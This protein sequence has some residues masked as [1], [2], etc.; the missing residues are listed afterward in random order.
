[1][2]QTNPIHYLRGQLLG[3]VLTENLS[4]RLY[5]NDASPYEKL[6][7][8][9]IRPKNAQDCI[10]LVKYA[11][12]HNI[13]VTARSAGTSLAGQAIGEGLIVDTGRYMNRI[14]QID[15]NKRMAKVE[16]GVVRSAL[17]NQLQSFGLQFGPDPSTSDYC[18]L[19]GMVGN[20]AWGLHSLR[21]GTTRDRIVAAKLLFSEGSLIELGPLS[22]EQLQ[23]KLIQQSS[24]GHLYRTVYDVL[25]LHASKIRS[26]F[27]RPDGLSR[28]S[29]YALDDMLNQQPWSPQGEPFNLARLLC[30]AEGTLGLVTELT[31]KLDPLPKETLLC[32]LSFASLGQALR[33]VPEL[34]TFK[35][36]ALELLDDKVL[37]STLKSPALEE[38]RFWLKGKPGAVLLTEF[39]ADYG[40]GYNLLSGNF[41]QFAQRFSSESVAI[42][43]G[44]K[45]QKVW[46]LRKAGLGSLMGYRGTV[47]PVTGVED[48][49]V[50]VTQLADYVVEVKRYLKTLDTDCVVYGPAGR[51][52]L[53][54]R[55]LMDLTTV[56]GQKRYVT[57]M[58]QVNQI[59]KAYG[60]TVTG[61]HGDGRMRAWYLQEFL[62]VEM[63]A[64]MQQVKTAFDSSGVFN[65]HIIVDA[66]KPDN[67][68]RPT[69][70]ISGKFETYFDWTSE[71]GLISAS[72]QCNGAGVCLSVTAKT[73]FCPSYQATREEQHGT[74]GRANILRQLLINDSGA[75]DLTHPDV[76]AI[77]DYCLSCKTCKHECPARV[78]L[79]QLKAEFL[80][81]YYLKHGRPLR[82]R[83]ISVFDR[84]N[85]V[86]ARIPGLANKVMA[87]SWV[88]HCLGFHPQRKLPVYQKD[89][90]SRW[91]KNCKIDLYGPEECEVLLLIDPYVEVYQPELAQAAVCILKRMDIAFNVSDCLSMG[92]A[93]I[94]QGDLFSARK[95]LRTAIQHLLPFAKA[96]LPLLSLEASEWSVWRDEAEKLFALE[97][98]VRQQIK[99][100]KKCVFLFE[101]W[102]VQNKHLLPTYRLAADGKVR[103]YL[104]HGH[105]HQKALSTMQCTLEV[106]QCIPNAE[107]KLIES[108]CCGMAGSFGY[109]REHFEVSMQI[110]EQHLFPAIRS[111]DADSRVVANGFSCRQQIL[112]GLGQKALHPVEALAEVLSDERL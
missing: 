79:A 2:T 110:A 55:P 97:P 26:A 89:S 7:L 56:V 50:P 57:M 107:V 14:L 4:R 109:E 75:V 8:A 61:K 43:T 74:R 3:D 94:S 95:R 52:V 35:P 40:N 59:V 1:M 45:I 37:Q 67:D 15:E 91:V 9:V 54:I 70:V 20:N 19:G 31:V 65:P 103:R 80:Q 33:A 42:V 92:R 36:A 73:G 49:A 111:A 76:K 12:K 53:H 25:N 105:C 106:L 88:K 47:K 17:N 6:P 64:V 101:Q 48:A 69:T 84:L 86:A 13:A 51:G 66:P 44:E 82:N 11:A 27:P 81:H 78:D 32:C 41:K 38:N 63:I 85:S 34:L 5:A 10:T 108:G 28:N 71:Q 16:P 72:R 83:L 24:E 30:G 18:T 60:G 99:K 77:L 93:Q 87:N 90:F 102:L 68:L 100:I 21:Y 29:G 46:A 23:Q 39:H 62:G 58:D 22:Q 104:V 112:G 96:G 98:D